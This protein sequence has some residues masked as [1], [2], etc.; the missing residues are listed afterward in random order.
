MR[1]SFEVRCRHCGRS[2]GEYTYDTAGA[3]ALAGT[4]WGYRGEFMYCCECREKLSAG[5]D[6]IR[7]LTR[8]KVHAI[9]RIRLESLVD[10]MR[11]YEEAEDT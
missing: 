1:E 2:V 7:P 11:A 3:R 9:M 10:V 6:Y 5:T 4:G 8:G